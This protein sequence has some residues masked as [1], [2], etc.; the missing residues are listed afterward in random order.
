MINKAFFLY[1]QFECSNIMETYLKVL[2]YGKLFR[3][4]IKYYENHNAT[5]LPTDML[6]MLSSVNNATTA[7][8]NL[9]CF[10]DFV[11]PKLPLHQTVVDWCN[12]DEGDNS[13]LDGNYDSGSNEGDTG[14]HED[15]GC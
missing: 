8:Q 1:L 15:T 12:K 2:L 9:P 11:I 7:F 10:V 5:G 3:K 4:F 14:S 13:D 6:T